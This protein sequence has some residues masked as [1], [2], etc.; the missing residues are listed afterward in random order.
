MLLIYSKLQ[1]SGL[2]YVPLFNRNFFLTERELIVPKEEND[3]CGSITLC[4]VHSKNGITCYSP[5]KPY[6]KKKG[7]LYIKGK[8]LFSSFLKKI[9][10]S[11]THK[12]CHPAVRNRLIIID[13]ECYNCDKFFTEF[14]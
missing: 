12:R 1:T 13:A 2:A 14:N 9:M 6:Y 4:Q 8:K 11:I 10:D 5:Q 7:M 3:S